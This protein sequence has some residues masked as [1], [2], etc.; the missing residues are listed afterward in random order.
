[1]HPF[2]VYKRKFIL[3]LSLT[4]FPKFLSFNKI[5]SIEYKFKLLPIRLE[6]FQQPAV[7]KKLS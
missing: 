5:I 2:F 6:M 7:I 4:D 1:M 3:H